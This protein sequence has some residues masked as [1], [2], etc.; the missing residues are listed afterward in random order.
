MLA[1]LARQPALQLHTRAALARLPLP[2]PTTP[3]PSSFSSRSFSSSTRQQY[4]RTDRGTAQKQQQQSTEELKASAGGKIQTVPFQIT[5]ERGL[6]ISNTAAH[7]A[8]GV[9]YVLRLLLARFFQRFFGVSPEAFGGFFHT[10]VRRIAFKPLLL[11]VWKVDLAMQGKALLDQCEMSLG[12]SALNASL[13]GFRLDPLDRL[14]ASPPLDPEEA[15]L[16]PFSPSKHLT[17][18][19]SLPSSTD[20]PSGTPDVALIPFTRTP[21]NLLDKL[22]SFPRSL[23]SEGLSFDPKRFKPVLF[24]AYPIY[25]PM[26][27]AE[28]EL[29]EIV[30]GEEEKR[31]VTTA[32]FATTD[33]TAFAV[34]PQFLNPPTWLPSSSAVDL[35][36]SGRPTN[37]D[38]APSSDS[39]KD[40]KPKL[41]EALEDLKERIVGE[42][43][44]GGIEGGMDP[45][46][47][48]E[49]VKL[50]EGEGFEA[51][52]ERQGRALGFGDH[53]DENREYIDAVFEADS[54]EAFLQQIENLPDTA[55]PVLVSSSSLPKISSRED[56]L[57]S[58][59]SKVD[60]ARAKV[61]ALKP[62][63]LDAVEK[64][65][66]ERKE[67]ERRASAQKARAR[68]RA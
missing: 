44:A 1:P 15:P 64:E 7:S 35:S 27:L 46:A 53:A 10:G 25:L 21:L 57:A 40:L 36:I 61:A 33:G 56:L 51:Y 8:F 24:A 18:F 47:I 38:D 26:Y 39:L 49:V 52:V 2:R 43:V 9:T 31:R 29:E 14:S 48:T 37:P 68:G 65:D 6:H 3:L 62:E 34:Y 42:S 11:P 58:I 30:P 16:E 50:K 63:W 41:E 54:A 12:I 5:P 22:S 59:R 20:F 55:R 45:A 13:P 67:K 60:A 17:P 4:P 66:K 32:A 19:S 28:F 23:A